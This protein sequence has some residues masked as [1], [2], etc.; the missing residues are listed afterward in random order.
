MMP[1]R[2][3]DSLSLYIIHVSGEIYLQLTIFEIHLPGVRTKWVKYVIQVEGTNTN[4]FKGLVGITKSFGVGYLHRRWRWYSRSCNWKCITSWVTVAKA[5]SPAA[6]PVVKF[7]WLPFCSL[8]GT[9]KWDYLMTQHHS[10]EHTASPP[11]SI[12]GSN[13]TWCWRSVISFSEFI[14]F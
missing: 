2:Q 6:F 13:H 3:Y 4:N 1:E 7:C 12:Q 9:G 11:I 14:L 5:S 8:E 10:S